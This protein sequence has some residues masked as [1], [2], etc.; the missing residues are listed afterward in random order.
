MQTRQVEL[1]RGIERGGVQ[2][3]L[4]EIREQT[5]E[6]ILI[7]NRPRLVDGVPVHPS[8]NEASVSIIARRLVKLG[9]LVQA[10]LGEIVVKQLSADDFGRL[11]EACG[12]LDTELA[13]WI[14]EAEKARRN[15]MGKEKRM[16][17]PDGEVLGGR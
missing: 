14:S 17:G 5:V 10:E 1:R 9:D 7:A 4:A 2:H 6:D 12:A 13:G 16:V 3:C 8:V 15:A 11:D